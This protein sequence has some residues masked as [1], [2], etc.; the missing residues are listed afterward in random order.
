MNLLVPS[1]KR[2]PSNN[3]LPKQVPLFSQSKSHLLSFVS[4]I[5]KIV[6]FLIEGTQSKL[7]THKKLFDPFK[8]ES[9]IR[10]DNYGAQRK[11]LS[12]FPGEN[13]G[14]VRR[15]LGSG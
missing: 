14:S 12:L 11:S 8:S 1:D 9:K 10:G 5:Q 13:K 6:R 2:I 4:P 3:S 15:N 7:L